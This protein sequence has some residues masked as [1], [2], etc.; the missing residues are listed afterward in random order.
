MENTDL[1]L[2]KYYKTFID[3]KKKLHENN[4]KALELFKE[5][6]ELLNEIKKNH[7]DKIKEHQYI[8]N[9]SE[10]ECN[11]YINLT[12]ESS[13]ESE[14]NKPEHKINV[15]KLYENLLYGNLDLIKNAKFGQINFKQ[16]INNDKQII[17][18]DKQ[19]INNDKQTILHYAIKQCDTTF[20]KYAFKLGARIDTTNS[21]GNTLLE[22]ACLEQDPNMINFL[23]L[24][25]A[26]MQKH[27]YFRD[28]TIK[29]IT[30]NDSIDINI[31]LKTIL[32]YISIKIDNKINNKIY[33]KLK[34]I[35]NSI[36]LNESINFNNCSFKHLFIGLNILLHKL[37]ETSAL[38]YLNIISEELS[39]ILI[40]NKLGCPPN[41]LEIILSNLVPFIDYPFNISI[42]WI[43]SLELKYLIL[44]LIKN[45]TLD[46][47]KELIENLWELYIKNKIVQEDYLGCLISQ[48]I[49]KIKV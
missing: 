3:G 14:F 31:L 41:K 15:D 18:N 35:E 2:K 26:N 21:C 13:I 32:S 10:S 6:L 5:S 42:D 9:K 29:N 11:K 39:Y 4:D 48:W 22:Y 30:N 36:N 34:L 12:I 7:S 43:I 27:L 37:S 23:G 24:Y 28:G 25:G 33:N 19:I 20:L 44:K 17:N 8:L 47:K 49:T 46:I 1:L 16:L 40:N 38:T 45:N